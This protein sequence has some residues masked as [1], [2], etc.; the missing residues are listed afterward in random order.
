VSQVIDLQAL[1]RS[2]GLECRTK[3]ATKQRHHMCYAVMEYINGF[4]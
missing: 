1:C 3:C 2:R 4:F